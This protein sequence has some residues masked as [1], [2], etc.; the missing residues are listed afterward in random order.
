MS[1]PPSSPT[2]P[3]PAADGWINL[4]VANDEQ[5]QPVLRRGGAAR[6]RR[7]SALCQAADRVRHRDV[8]VPIV[9]A[10][11]RTPNPRRMART[12]DAR[13]IPGGAI[14]SVG[15][16]CDSEILRARDMIAHSACNAGTIKV[17][18][19]PMQFGT[20]PLETYRAPPRLGEH[21]GEVRPRGRH[22][23]RRTA[24]PAI[25]WY[26]LKNRSCDPC[27]GAET[28]GRRNGRCATRSQP[29]GGLRCPHARAPCDARGHADRHRPARH[30]RR[31][32]APAR[33]C[34]PTSCWSSK[35]ERCGRRRA[36]SSSSRMFAESCRMW[37]AW[38]LAPPHSI[39]P[40]ADAR[41][42]CACPIL[43]S[44]LLLPP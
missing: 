35:A 43:L 22:G 2:R 34:S 32:R 25:R 39:P 17:I 29:A 41:S 9:R 7:G 33:A 19:N 15:E 42:T 6:F 18:K 10:V 16:V 31:A 5:W 26:R 38:R 3:S 23:R 36:R 4:A 14:R 24:S 12:L 13:G 8:L 1:M 44:A 11:L 27:P 30:E 21:T 37:S 28:S 40:T 20:T